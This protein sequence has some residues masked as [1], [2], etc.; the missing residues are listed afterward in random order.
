M[1]P[2]TTVFQRVGPF[3][4]L[5]ELGRGGMAAVFLARDS[6]SDRTV[7]L[8]LVP[9]RDDRE[10]REI[11]EAERSG[12]KLQAQLSAI[13]PLVPRV[14]DEGEVPP[15][16][17]FIAMEYVE[18]ENL[19]DLIA[20][21]PVDP[22]RAAG[23]AIDLCRFL[24]AAHG[25]AATVDGRAFCSLVHGD[26][27][28]RNVRI[29]ADGSLKVL[30]F[31]I[32][33]ALSLSRKVTRNDFG[34][35]PY[36]SPERLDSVEVNAHADLWA[37]GVILH[38]MLASLPPF[39]ARDTRRLEEQIRAGYGPRQLPPAIPTGLR[40][41]VARLLASEIDQRYDTAALVLEDLVRFRAGDI[42]EA[43]RLGWPAKA[44]DAATRRTRPPEPPDEK[45]R[46]T[47]PASP[48]VAAAAARRARAW[49]P[50]V[51][52]PSRRSVRAALLLLVFFL[53]V[54]E[55]RV[56]VAAG[57]IAASAATRDLEELGEVW[58]DY[59]NLTQR[60][61]LGVGVARLRGTLR[62]RA[63]QLAGQVIDDYRAG[64]P[65]IRE[66]QWKAA[67][68]N[69]QHALAVAPDDRWLRAALRYCDGHLNRI[70]GE[71]ARSRRQTVAAGRHFSEAI[72]AFREAAEL[73]SDWP[74]PFLGLARTFIYGVE[75]IERAAD[76][77]KQA[78]RLG[79]KVGDRETSQLADGYRTRAAR[80]GETARQ[81][82]DLPQEPEYLRRSLEAYREA[83]SLY[84]RIP[85]YPGVPRQLRRIHEAMDQ[86][87]E[88]LNEVELM[89]LAPEDSGS[90]PDVAAW[91][92]RDLDLIREGALTW[93]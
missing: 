20:R 61:Y 54:N 28:P 15:R 59:D 89:L 13:C 53:V 33:K 92:A 66:R 57:R 44:D 8:K 21:G 73:R 41:I 86:T 14:Y 79:Y 24:D 7:A 45:T 32:A 27:K 60:S 10:H 50:R 31:G 30:D 77:L 11:L 49:F 52:R 76:A 40:A 46:R 58:G 83:Q 55:V 4:V 42:P 65:S 82:R 70:D 17:Y 75:D 74:D 35:M 18:G 6:R 12:A 2:M 29:A 71:A 80:L 5:E 62:R 3:E 36:L 22:D 9:M 26:L 37:L 63:R 67:R 51:P 69:L 64:L 16:Y 39:H 34:S 38:E 19:S 85:A 87:Q 56:G 48:P 25:F 47:R 84:E 88:R 72:S 1:T 91:P 78:E 68:F 90:E 43:Q 81:L 93:A 23:L